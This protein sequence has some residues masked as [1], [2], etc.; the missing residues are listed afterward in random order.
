VDDEEKGGTGR[1]GG[2]GRIVEAE[3]DPLADA[4]DAADDLTVDG[5]DRRVDRA[6]NERAVQREPIE[7]ASDDIARQR[8]EVADNVGKFRDV[9][10]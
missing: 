4:A 9:I 7:P 1:R 5:L 3:D 10:S 2:I 8:V 6:E